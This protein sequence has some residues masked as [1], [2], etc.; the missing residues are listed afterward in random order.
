MP[1]PPSQA[2]SQV[3][4]DSG[5][6]PLSISLLSIQQPVMICPRVTFLPPILLPATILR[7]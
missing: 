2:M 3:V 4:G 7:T 5:I 6:A 1:L